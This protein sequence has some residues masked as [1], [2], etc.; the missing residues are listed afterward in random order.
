MYSSG[1][2]FKGLQLAAKI[3][4]AIVD[5]FA[6]TSDLSAGLTTGEL[7]ICVLHFISAALM[8]CALNM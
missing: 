6:T 3:V 8:M 5:E 2:D 7:F 4:R 1:T